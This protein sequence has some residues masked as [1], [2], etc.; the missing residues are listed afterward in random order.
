MT[1]GFSWSVIARLGLVQA[2]IGAMVMI[3]T[4]LLNRVMVVELALA[5]AIPAGLV[6]WHYAVQLS[7]PV[8]GHG[9][10]KG[11]RRTPWI[12]GGMGVL[13]LGTVLAVDA[14]PLMGSGSVAGYL[15]GVTAFALIGGGVGAAGTS[16]LALLASGVAPD[17]R[18]GAAALT[19]I[20]MVAGIAV[21]AGVVGSLIEPFS[22]GRLA[23]VTGGAVLIAFA[24]ALLAIRG[25]EGRVAAAPATEP[26]SFP[27]ALRS[28]ARDPAARR[29]TAFVFVSMLAYSM[30]DLILEPFGGLVFQLNAGTTTQ[31]SGVHHGGI[32]AGMIATGVLGGAFGGRRPADLE[33]WIVAGCVVSAA[34]LAGLTLGTADPARWPL[35]PNLIVLGLGNGMFAAAAV[36]TMMGLAAASGEHRAGTRMG[37]WGAAQAVA[38]GLGGLGGAL[39]VDLLREA[40]GA[41]GIAFQAAFAGE[42][43]LFLWSALL[44][45]R[46]ARP[47]V[48]P[49]QAVPA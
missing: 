34:A 39:V 41:D 28:M 42:A 7:R 46:V 8:W 5:A 9:S 22:Y 12:V 35:L 16:L 24:V 11:R 26:E 29:F 1:T 6:A 17:R 15:L 13:A 37:V 4:S 10:D 36:G 3:S 31:L 23:L 47:H 21:S 2:A 18:A 40:A 25:V 32:L 30:Q 43:L 14:A 38:F 49:A 48:H 44:A 27:D 19:W 33:R 20:M 45:V